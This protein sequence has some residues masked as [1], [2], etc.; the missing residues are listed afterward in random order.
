MKNVSTMSK[1]S[2][3]HMPCVVADFSMASRFCN[4]GFYYYFGTHSI[5]KGR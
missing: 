1:T 2:S 4:G 3:K 5:R